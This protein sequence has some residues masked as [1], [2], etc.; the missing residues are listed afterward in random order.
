M[1]YLQKKY[2]RLI[3][4]TLIPFKISLLNLILESWSLSFSICNVLCRLAITPLIGMTKSIV[5]NPAR[6]ATPKY[7]HNM[8]T[9]IIICIGALHSVHKY[10]VSSTKEFAFTCIKL[11]ISPT[12]AALR[13]CGDNLKLLRIIKLEKCYL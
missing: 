1:I 6:V 12:V 10:A 9:A 5:N 13:A 8:T 3:L 7:D 2:T 4:F 11:T